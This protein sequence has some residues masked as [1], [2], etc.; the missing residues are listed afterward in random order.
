MKI[1]V[2]GLGTVGYGVIEILTNEKTRLEKE[3]KQ[4]IVVKYGCGLEEVDLP[5]EIIYTK[6]YH[7]VINDEEID[8]VVELIGGTTIAKNIILE[9][10]NNKK[11]VVTANKALLAHYGKEIFQTAKAN[12]VHIFYE[13]SVGGGIPVL[14]SQKESLIANNT[15]EIVGILNGT[16]NFILTLMENEIAIVNPKVIILFGNQVSSIFLKE[17]ISVS[18][19]R[20]KKYIKEINNKKYTCFPVYYPIGN[21]RFNIDKSIEDILWIKEVYFNEIHN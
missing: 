18:T 8:V 9:A 20:K 19:T 15:K 11:H 10:L 13:A 16:T 17:K 21:G 12:D 5:K 7:D 4:E 3:M 2:I 6:D 1:G 14:A